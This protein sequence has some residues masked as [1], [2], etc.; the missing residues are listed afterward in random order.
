MVV[1]ISGQITGIPNRNR[2]AF[3]D[4]AE[5]VRFEFPQVHCKIINP[6]AV[7]ERVD[8][9][10]AP[11]NMDARVEDEKKP[12]WSD[13]MRECIRE[14]TYATHILMLTGWEKSKGATAEKEL[15][16]KLGIKVCYSVD[17][18]IKSYRRAEQTGEW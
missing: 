1:Y 18:L 10:F 8:E 2:F 12:T 11:A 3:N 17:D 14:L 4:A 7:G 5:K 9:R 13:Y 6:V 15:S 16:E